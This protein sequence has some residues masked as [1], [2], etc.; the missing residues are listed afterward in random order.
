M[1][2]YA[3]YMQ[4]YANYMHDVGNLFAYITLFVFR[5]ELRVKYVY[6]YSH[7]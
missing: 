5:V 2:K 6:E 1:Q 7:F 3:N 4:K